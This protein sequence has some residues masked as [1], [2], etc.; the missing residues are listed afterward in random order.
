MDLMNI[1]T[2]AKNR[3]LLCDAEGVMP[4]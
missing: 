2:I 1:M 3:I 4:R